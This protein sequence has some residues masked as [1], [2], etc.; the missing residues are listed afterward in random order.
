MKEISTQQIEALLQTIYSTNIPAQTFDAVRKMLMEL[1]EV[2]K[3]EPK[4]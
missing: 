2:K 1:P 3:E 4:K